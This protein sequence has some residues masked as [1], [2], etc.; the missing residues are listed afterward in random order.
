M[1]SII[2]IILL[3]QLGFS[4]TNIKE[5]VKPSPKKAIITIA[6]IVGVTGVALTLFGFSSS[7]KK[8]RIQERDGETVI[9]VGPEEEYQPNASMV[10]GLILICG[11]IFTF[12]Y[13]SKLAE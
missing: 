11:S 3:I 9:N 10:I 2:S 12:G 5:E 6:S 1:K 8:N 4:E 7:E 13:A